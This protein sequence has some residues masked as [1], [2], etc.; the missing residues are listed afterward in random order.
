[1]VELALGSYSVELVQ[2]IDAIVPA[3]ADRRRIHSRAGVDHS[4]R[5]PVVSVRAGV[6]EHLAGRL[7]IDSAL[8]AVSLEIRR[9]T[10][11]R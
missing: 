11:D 2:L 6:S 4:S 7:S 1:M 5:R 10:A 8:V 3:A 9:A